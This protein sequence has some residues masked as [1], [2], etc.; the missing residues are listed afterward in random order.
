MS[1]ES[2]RLAQRAFEDVTNWPDDVIEEALCEADC[3]TGGKGW[4]V[5]EETCKNF[6][7]RG[8][9]LFAAHYLSTM[10]PSGASVASGYVEGSSSFAVSSKSVGNESVSFDTGS[11]S[12]ASLGDAWLASTNYGMQFMRLRKRAGMGALAV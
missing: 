4:G 1:I 9:F 5:F 10:Y 8:M 6:K 3:E 11:L 7:R 12:N 2:F